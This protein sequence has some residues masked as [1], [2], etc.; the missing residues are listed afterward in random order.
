MKMDIRRCG[1]RVLD[2]TGSRVFGLYPGGIPN[3]RNR[4]LSK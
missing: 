3:I 1:R 2:I 4:S